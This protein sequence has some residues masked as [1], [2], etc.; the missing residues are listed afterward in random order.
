MKYDTL[1]SSLLYIH[2]KNWGRAHE[3]YTFVSSLSG[4]RL[5]SLAREFVGLINPLLTGRS[6]TAATTVVPLLT[7]VTVVPL[8]TPVTV[9]LLLTAEVSSSS[10]TAG[11]S[12]SPS[13]RESGLSGFS[14]VSSSSC[15]L[16]VWSGDDFLS[17]GGI[18]LNSRSETSD[19]IVLPR[20]NSLSLIIEVTVPC[21]LLI[22]GKPSCFR[23]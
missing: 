16:M 13:A 8:G 2:K 15:S 19:I 21:R 20:W 3:N 9:V 22:L 7:A 10:F 5:P 6:L 18:H 23:I 14:S 1:A 4:F 17:K 12:L 11:C